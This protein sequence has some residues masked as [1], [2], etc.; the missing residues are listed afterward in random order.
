MNITAR[1]KFIEDVGGEAGLGYGGA[2]SGEVRWKARA[3]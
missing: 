3:Q 2:S 1:G